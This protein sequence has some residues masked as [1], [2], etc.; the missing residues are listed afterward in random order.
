MAVTS[1]LEQNIL[2]HCKIS[3]YLLGEDFGLYLFFIFVWNIQLNVGLWTWWL[4]KGSG[5]I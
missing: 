5:I 4:E 1:T 2:R 3:F